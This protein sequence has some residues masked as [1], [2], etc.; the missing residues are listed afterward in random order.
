MMRT[1][2][3]CVVCGWWWVVIRWSDYSVVR[4][5]EKKTQS[6]KIKKNGFI[7]FDL[8]LMDLD[9]AWSLKRPLTHDWLIDSECECVWV[10]ES[11]VRHH[12]ITSLI[13]HWNFIFYP[14]WQLSSMIS[15]QPSM[16]WSL[17]TTCFLVVF[18]CEYDVHTYHSKTEKHVL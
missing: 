1:I 8:N 4:W 13:K 11:G 9:G 5:N 3:E 16:W 17:H 10:C 18:I 2:Y 15:I 7:W 14:I 6:L 12:W